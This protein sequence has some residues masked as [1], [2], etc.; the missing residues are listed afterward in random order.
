MKQ[1]NNIYIGLIS[2]IIMVCGISCQRVD[3]SK[4]DDTKP[5]YIKTALTRVNNDLVFFEDRVTELRMLIFNVNSGECLYNSKLSFPGDDLEQAS[6]AIE[7]KPG[8][9]DFLFIANE[10]T[11]GATFVLNL[12][13]IGNIVDLDK[14]T[15]KAIDYDPNYT[16]TSTSGF[17]MSAFYKGLVVNNNTTRDNP[18]E[19]IVELIR[20]MAKVEVI[21]KN[22]DP[23]MSTPKR[24]TEVYLE[25]VPKYYTVPASPDIYTVTGTNMGIS[26]KYPEIVG[27]AIFTEEEYEEETIGSLIFYVPEFLRPANSTATGAMTLVIGATRISSSPFK[28]VIDHQNFNDNE[29]PRGEFNDADYSRYSIIRGTHYQVT[30]NM[31]PTAPIEATVKVLPWTLKSASVKFGNLGYDINVYVGTNDVTAQN[32]D[33]RQVKI[34]PGETVRFVFNLNEPENAVWRATLNNGGEFEFISGSVVRGVAGSGVAEFT[35]KPIIDGWPGT[36][37]ET[38]VYIVVFLNGIEEVPLIP[39]T[40]AQGEPYEGVGNRYKIIQVEQI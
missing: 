31:H 40:N 9:F 32:F 6:S 26:K 25:N 24:L 12:N 10:S 7:W 3:L 33:Q 19:L 14:A 34:L 37:I 17:L 13:E 29:G 1:R 36:P 21:F 4:N 23:N 11:A 30:V 16:P 28:V 18:Q 15:F 2:L 8:S 5:G 39:G 22:V 38:E 27:G 35:I 20:S